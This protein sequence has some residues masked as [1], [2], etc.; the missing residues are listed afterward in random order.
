MIFKK[1]STEESNSNELSES[2][3]T[4]DAFGRSQAMIEFTPD[5]EI[6]TANDNFLGALG[7]SLDEIVGRHHRMFVGAEHAA[8]AE[9]RQ[10]WGDLA[11]GKFSAG[12]YQRFTK[13]NESIWISASYNPVMD[14]TGKTV[15]VVKI[16]SDITETK[17][18]SI[19]QL[20]ILEALDVSQAM[21]QFN[22]D[23]TIITANENF[24][25]T[26]GYTLPEIQ[27]SHHRMFCDRE[28]VNS[29]EYTDFWNRL[30][31]GEHFAGRFERR[32]KDGSTV[33]IQA[34]YNPVLGEDGKP[35]KIV[36]YAADISSQIVAENETKD[37]ATSVGNAVASS[38]SQ[39]A[40]T[41][42]EISDSVGKTAKLANEATVSAEAS[43]Q[44]AKDLQHSSEKI[45]KVVGVIQ[46]LADQTNLLALNATIEAARAGEQ[47]RGFAVVANE[48][49]EL[50]KATCNE[51]QN[52]EETVSEIQE[53]ITE[54]IG[55]VDA[56]QVG[57]RE[58]SSN[59]NTV[60]SAIE[61]QSITMT[62]L[63]E[64]AEALV[65]LAQQS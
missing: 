45:G 19:D 13:N 60:A 6:L 56:I 12:E 63:S 38:A 50:A 48:V 16:A 41:I 31:A 47:G 54:M 21:I 59:T 44:S 57:V 65:G 29:H 36:K 28:Y 55:S 40:S 64:T 49:K 52:I 37:E 35:Y 20:A 33:W 26:L 15:K 3:M 53:K 42:G 2:Q 43:A 27:G 58:V 30:G 22:I 39:M 10:F 5:G 7:Y 18:E 46:D 24:L 32:A 14:E 61:E 9:Y 11:R 17:R 23:G 51:T 4:L 62:S 8:S 1:R 25:A 34:T